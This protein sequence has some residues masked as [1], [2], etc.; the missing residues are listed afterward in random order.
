MHAPLVTETSGALVERSILLAIDG[1]N[2]TLGNALRDVMWAHPHIQLAS[3]TQEHPTSTDILLRCQTSGDIS[4][5]QGVVEALHMA[6]A[7]LA[8]MGDSMAAAHEEWERT[9]AAGGGARQQQQERRGRRPE[10]EPMDEGG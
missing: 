4:A 3:Y 6:K 2:H 8:Q 10:A 7:M 5:E 1:E 9:Q